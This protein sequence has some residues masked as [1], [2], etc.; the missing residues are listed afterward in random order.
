MKSVEKRIKLA[1]FFSNG[2]V[3][4]VGAN[5]LMTL[6]KTKKKQQHVFNHLV[7]LVYVPIL[8]YHAQLNISCSS[9][10]FIFITYSFG[11]Q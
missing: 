10:K 3:T 4:P 9:G 8:Y 5:R 2:Q 11:Y 1:D 6:K 7:R